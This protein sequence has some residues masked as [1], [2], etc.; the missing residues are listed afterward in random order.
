MGRD[1]GWHGQ[2]PLS[3][4]WVARVSDGL[5]VCLEF[6][7]ASAVHVSDGVSAET[8]GQDAKDP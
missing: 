6:F 2:Q 7:G 8:D 1:G 4:Q 5:V 3:Q